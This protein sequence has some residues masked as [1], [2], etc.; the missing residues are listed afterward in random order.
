VHISQLSDNFIKNPA[1]IVKVHQKV[2]VTVLEVDLPRKRIALSMKSRPEIGSASSGSRTNDRG[3]KSRGESTTRNTTAKP[4]QFGGDW[5]T[6][7]L[8]KK[9]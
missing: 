9:Q 1:D 3:Q 5:F 7:A 4:A 8:N 2:Q 6:Q